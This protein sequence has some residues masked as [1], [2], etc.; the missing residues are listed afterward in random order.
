[1]SRKRH[2]D[3]FPQIAGFQALRLAARKAIRGKHRQADA[4]RVHG[5]PGTGTA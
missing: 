2:D 3:L 5:R 4:G 1:M